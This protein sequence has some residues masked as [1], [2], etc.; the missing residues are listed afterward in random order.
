MKKRTK[1]KSEIHTFET[2]IEPMLKIEASGYCE[3]GHAPIT[4]RAPEDCD[5]GEL[6][7]VEDFHVYLIAKDK[8]KLEITDYLDNDT[9]EDLKSDLME[10]HVDSY[11]YDNDAAHEASA[12]K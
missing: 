3:P 2:E 10:D 11:N 8:P 5:P 6:D 1:P 9:I 7:N 12:G 4:H